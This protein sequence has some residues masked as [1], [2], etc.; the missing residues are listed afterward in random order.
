M[1]TGFS[2]SVHINVDISWG[3]PNQRQVKGNAHPALSPCLLRPP[4]LTQLVTDL[5]GER[6]R[7]R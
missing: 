1:Q 4:L 7:G 5:S 2:G 3:C 6:D